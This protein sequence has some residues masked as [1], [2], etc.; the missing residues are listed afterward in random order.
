MS[1]QAYHY[2]VTCEADNH[3]SESTIYSLYRH[4]IPR[5][6]IRRRFRDTDLDHARLKW[7]SDT[8]D[9][10]SGSGAGAGAG[11]RLWGGSMKGRS[12]GGGGHARAISKNSGSGAR[13]APELHRQ[14]KPNL[15]KS[16]VYVSADWQM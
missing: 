8:N 13:S 5:C 7:L 11:A 12:P 4:L 6:P 16:T 14:R 2:A 9:H 15:G 10:R 1:N 3:Y